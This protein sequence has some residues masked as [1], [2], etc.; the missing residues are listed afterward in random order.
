MQQC[1][2]AYLSFDNTDLD[3][4][5]TY[6]EGPYGNHASYSGDVEFIS[7]N[8]SCGNMA[9]FD[10]EAEIYFD[11]NI[12]NVPTRAITIAFWLYADNLDYK[13]ILF[14]AKAYG[15]PVCKYYQVIFYK[16]PRSSFI[17]S[18]TIPISLKGHIIYG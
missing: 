17:R 18:P 4:N 2:V 9:K 13:Q 8:S 16:I 1:L 14:T 5:E 7:D 12:Q 6:D 3:R 11:P 15:S 10:E